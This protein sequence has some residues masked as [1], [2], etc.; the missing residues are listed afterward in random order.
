MEYDEKSVRKGKQIQIPVMSG[1]NY[2]FRFYGQQNKNIIADQT[3]IQNRR[4]KARYMRIVL[5]ILLF[6]CLFSMP[7]WYFEIIRILVVIYF[8]K[9]A[10]DYRNKKSYW[11]YLWIFLIILFQPFYKISLGRTL[12]NIID[13]RS[14]L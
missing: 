6:L 11:L 7:Y 4:Y 2:V 13:T 9:L 8:S 14:A 10:Y 3:I 12:W 5:A 1:L